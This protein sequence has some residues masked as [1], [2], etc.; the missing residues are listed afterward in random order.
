MTDTKLKGTTLSQELDLMKH[1]VGG[2]SPYYY[3]LLEEYVFLE[4]QAATLDQLGWD[5]SGE[6]LSPEMSELTGGL[7]GLAQRASQRL[8]W[9]ETAMHTERCLG[10]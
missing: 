6:Y 8:S 7:Y 10:A 5:E 9:L 1:D 4:E 3:I 2:Y